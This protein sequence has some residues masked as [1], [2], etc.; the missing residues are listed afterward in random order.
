MTQIKTVVRILRA[1]FF[2]AVIVPA[3]LG[4]AIAWQHGAFH[5]GY[6]SLTLLGIVCINAGLNL[7]NDYFDHLSGNDEQNHELTPFSGGSRVIQDGTLAARR[8]LIASVVFYLAGMAIGLYLAW[9]RGWTL[10]WIG[11]IG[12]FIALFHNAPPFKLYYVAPG[13]GE[14]AAGIGCGPLIV[15][16]SYYVQAQRLPP[17][18]LWASLPVGLLTAAVLYIN[19]FPDYAADRAVGKRTLVVALGRARAVWG[20]VALLVAVY[21]A[22]A[23][24]VATRMLPLLTLFAFLSVPIAYRGVRGAMRFHSDIPRLIPTNAATIQLNVM[25]GLL[26]CGA[27]VVAG[28]V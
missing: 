28:F 25:T 14:L 12:V 19:E 26:L 22:V 2:T 16:G 13:V 4:A 7:S 18:V 15:L 20:Y 1:P 11:A 21:A 8:V 5:A 9:S 10:L 24:G 17:E 23:V 6:L 3:L 27:Y